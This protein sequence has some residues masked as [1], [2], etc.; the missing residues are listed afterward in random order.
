[1]FLRDEITI[2]LIGM[3]LVLLCVGCLVGWGRLLAQECLP[4]PG[5]AIFFEDFGSGPNPGSILPNGTTS[6]VYGSINTG[7]YVV[8]NTTVDLNP[9]LFHDGLDH[10]EGDEDGYMVIFNPADGAGIFYQRTFSGLCPNTHYI[11]SYWVANLSLPGACIGVAEKPNLL[12]SVIDLTDGSVVDS[13][14]TGQIWYSS[15]MTWRE[16]SLRFRTGPEQTILHVQLTNKA[17]SGC[18]GDLAIDDLSLRLCQV[19]REQSFDLCELPGGQLIVGDDTYT[20]PGTY[21]NTLPVLNSCNDTLVT[22]TL[23]GAARVLPLLQLAICEGDTLE[24]GG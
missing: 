10:T 5:P 8:R 6:Y 14:S 16:F 2:P 12:L 4:D 18:G 19:W 23:T 17:P 7:H 15:F 22:T 9:G 3:R 1:M 20:E 21:L 24:I 11:F 13:T